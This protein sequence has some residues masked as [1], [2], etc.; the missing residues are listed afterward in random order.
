MKF[1]HKIGVL[2]IVLASCSINA[3][4]QGTIGS[5]D[6]IKVNSYN[7]PNLNIVN[8]DDFIKL[9]NDNKSRDVY[10][11]GDQFIILGPSVM[12]TIDTNGYENIADYKSGND[13]KFSNGASYYFALEN[14]LPNQT[15]VDY[16]KQEGF[17][18]KED[19]HDAVRLGFTHSAIGSM[20][21]NGFITKE[22][23]QKNVKY[24]NRVS[25]RREKSS[26]PFCG[27]VLRHL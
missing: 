24:L 23:F 19:Y 25:S 4:T 20:S 2:A 21:I 7:S 27:Y 16:Y 11:T 15:E 22:D 12:Y 18:T 8:I 14:N 26:P 17:L 13:K 9:M 1:A 3:F 6:Y 10:V 5:V